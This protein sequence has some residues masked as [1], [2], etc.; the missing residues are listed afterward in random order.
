MAK[1]LT[2]ALAESEKIP[3]NENGVARIREII[4]KALAPKITVTVTIA[5]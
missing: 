5:R 3:Y 1:E 2:I 4:E